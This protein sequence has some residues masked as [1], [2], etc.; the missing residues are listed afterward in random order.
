MKFLI[1]NTDYPDFIEWLYVQHPELE[2]ESYDRQMQ[3]RAES[4]FG[5]ADFYSSNLRRLGHEACDLHVNNEWLQRQWAKEHGVHGGASIFTGRSV[6]A[7]LQ[8]VRRWAGRTPLR[9]LKPVVR[10][11]L[12]S[13]HEKQSWFN[14]ILAAQIRYHKPDV[15]L[16]QAMDGVCSQFLREMKSHA[17]LLVGQIASP[18][19]RNED[20]RVYDLVLS[21]LPNYVEYFRRMGVRAELQRFAFEPRIINRLENPGNK[22]EVSFVGSLSSHHKERIH[23]LEY[24]CGQLDMK[25]WGQGMDGLTKNSPV[26]RQHKGMAWGIGMYRILHQ[27]KVTLNHHIGIAESLANNMRLFEATGVGTLLITDWKTNLEE[28]FKIDQ[29]VVAYRT[30]QECAEK[31]RHYLQR[32]DER[33]SIAKAGQKRTLEEHTYDRRMKELVDLVRSYS[34]G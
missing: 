3:V 31:I 29:E 30:P 12:G 2:R 8:R 14:E 7:T 5:V 16:N 24:L 28:M 27:S 21:S 10:P 18:L 13:S 33:Q 25:V 15:I 11:V 17:R 1:I 34:G 4:L 26:R 19:P 23:L 9:F 6:R 32:E 20:F 22:I